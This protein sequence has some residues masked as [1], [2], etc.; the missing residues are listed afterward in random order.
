MSDFRK[1]L[2]SSNFEWAVHALTAVISG[3]TAKVIVGSLQ[4]FNLLNEFV[5]TQEKKST[6]T[7]VLND[8]FLC[9]LLIM[10]S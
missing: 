5:E 1:K 2:C 10:T 4:L 9:F 3:K 7:N 8:V 6:A